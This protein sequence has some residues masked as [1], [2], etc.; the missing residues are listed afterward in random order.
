[1]RGRGE[2]EERADPRHLA[3]ALLVASQDGALLTQT[4]GTAE[5][6]RVAVSAA[7]DY[8]VSFSRRT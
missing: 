5:Q 6:F 3:A 7:V 4:V 8:V 1:M 2:M